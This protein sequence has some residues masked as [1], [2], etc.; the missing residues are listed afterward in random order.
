M[1]VALQHAPVHECAGVALVRVAAN[2]FN[3]ALRRLGKFPFKPRGEARAAAP[4]KA[5]FEYNV[6]NVVAAHLRKRLGK[7]LVA[8]KGDVFVYIFRVYNAAVS[9]RHA[10]LLFVKIDLLKGAYLAVLRN[11]LFIKQVRDHPALNKM[12]AH[13]ALNVVHL[14]V[15][16]K[17][18]LRIHYA[19]G[20][21]F[22]KAEAARPHNLYFV[23]K[24][25]VPYAFLKSLYYGGGI[26]R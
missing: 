4:A 20:A 13:Y 6:Y 26:G 19:D 21:V 22:A 23:F 8:V 15:A 24:S 12:L 3:V 9:Q 10:L 14:N 16:V 5:A 11:A 1:R 2:V 17:R 25:G 7:R 18:A